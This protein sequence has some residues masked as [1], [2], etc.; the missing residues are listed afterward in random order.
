VDVEAGT[1]SKGEENGSVSYLSAA[2]SG[3]HASCA[4]AYE[5]GVLAS[6]AY[7]TPTVGTP[8]VRNVV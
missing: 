3:M 1:L 4:S 7:C 8:E 6:G 5:A 2:C